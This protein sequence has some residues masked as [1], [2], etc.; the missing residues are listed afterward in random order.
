MSTVNVQSNSSRAGSYELEADVVYHHLIKRP[1]STDKPLYLTPNAW[2][3]G[4]QE[5][6]CEPLQ[7]NGIR[8]LG[9]RLS[10]N[11]HEVHTGVCLLVKPFKDNETTGIWDAVPITLISDLHCL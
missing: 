5:R 10:G 1:T 9:C 2:F 11:T 8:L 7:C 3:Q 4:R 6:Y